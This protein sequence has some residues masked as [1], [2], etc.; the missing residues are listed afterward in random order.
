M[1]TGDLIVSGAQLGVGTTEGLST[2]T[3]RSRASFNLTGTVAMTGDAVTLEGT[4]TAFLAQLTVGDRINLPDCGSIFDQFRSV[5]SIESDTSLTVERAW[6]G[7]ET[8]LTAVALPS[9]I[10]VD[11]G[12]G[13]PRFI[14]NDNGGV[15][16]GTVTPNGILEVTG[17]GAGDFMYCPVG[18]RV[19][20]PQTS[21]AWSI[22]MSTDGDGG[23]KPGIAFWVSQLQDDGGATM[24]FTVFD[25]A[26]GYHQDI[27][28]IDGKGL[29]L[30]TGFHAHATY[31][32]SNYTI[33]TEDH[34]VNAHAAIGAL[35]ITL[36]DG[37]NSEG[38]MI[39]I[40][41]A[42]DSANAV[43]IAPPAG[44]TINGQ[45]TSKTL[46]QQYSGIQLVALGNTWVAS[47]LTPA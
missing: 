10:R 11:N 28:K 19:H 8:G 22:V 37:G 24:T 14:V 47:A 33:E 43:T 23:T 9:A 13:T 26:N 36:P 44:G 30:A 12:T 16:V 42:D 34:L 32:A 4:G 5:V 21:D 18:L 41:K 39:T 6:V 45:A 27:V 2:L 15:G 35:T 38:R 25:G 40:Y 29:H 7:T 3:V 20:L 1:A 46:T 31:V 17:E